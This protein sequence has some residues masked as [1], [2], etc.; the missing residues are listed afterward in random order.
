MK[1]DSPYRKRNAITPT[2][3]GNTTG[4]AMS[5]PRVLRP[6]KSNHSNRNA[7][8]MPIAAARITLTSET[9]TL[10]QSAAHS[11][12]RVRKARSAEGWA[13]STATTRIG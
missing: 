4:S 9:Q 12:E 3:G 10:A 2:R 13:A 5:A 11:P 8:G 7:S 6:G 1:P